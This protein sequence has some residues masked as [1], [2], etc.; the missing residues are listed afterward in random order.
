MPAPCIVTLVVCVGAGSGSAC[1]CGNNSASGSNA[2][3]LNS[4]GNAGRLAFT[5]TASIAGDT[6]RLI[7]S[8]MPDGSALYFQGTSEANGGAGAV[9]GDGLRCAGGTIVR[10]AQKA[11]AG[12]G[13]QYPVGAEASISVRGF[14]NAGVVLTYQCWYRNA[15]AFCT[16]DTYNLTNGVETTWQP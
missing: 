4:F 13:S 9:F 6:F 7:G 12:A 14:D 3:C 5:G 8:G 2:G 16:S 1:P 15:A 11:N 10:M